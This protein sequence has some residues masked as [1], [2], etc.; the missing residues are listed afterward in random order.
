HFRDAIDYKKLGF[1]HKAMMAMLKSQISK[2]PE[3]KRDDET[4]MMLETYGKT[5][6]FTDQSSI[7]L[8]IESCNGL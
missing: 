5:V 4:K 1:L 7:G 6:D 3:D 8:L 2:T